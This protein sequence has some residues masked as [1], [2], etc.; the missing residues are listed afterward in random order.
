MLDNGHIS[1]ICK[2][3]KQASLIDDIIYLLSVDVLK[4]SLRNKYVKDY[5]FGGID[6]RFIK[7]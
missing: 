7:L 6:S 5:T 4:H 2:A 1:N 3:L